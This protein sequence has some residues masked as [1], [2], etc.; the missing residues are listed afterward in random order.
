MCLAPSDLNAEAPQH[1][2]AC[3]RGGHR[4]G[5]S[6]GPVYQPGGFANAPSLARFEQPGGLSRGRGRLRRPT[7]C[8]APRLPIIKGGNMKECLDYDRLCE[9]PAKIALASSLGLHLHQVGRRTFTSKLLSMPSTQRSR[10]AADASRVRHRTD[11][12]SFRSSTWGIIGPRDAAPT[13]AKALF[14]TSL[15][16]RNGE[17]A[18]QTPYIRLQRARP[19]QKPA[20]SS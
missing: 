13:H 19:P 20:A 10:C 14:Q 4:S 7:S 2:M 18:I 15:K 16:R 5:R 1:K 8:S 17:N 6:G 3:H 12:L 11:L 9:I